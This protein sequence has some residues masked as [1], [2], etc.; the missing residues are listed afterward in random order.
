MKERPAQYGC[1]ATGT[2]Q[3][4]PGTRRAVWAR[5][6]CVRWPRR[7]PAGKC[8]VAARHPCRNS[9]RR[10]GAAT[11]DYALTMGVVLP[12]A[13]IVLWFGPRILRLVYEFTSSVIGWPFQ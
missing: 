8:C 10:R 9:P 7:S 1:Q 12:M 3:V 6:C 5:P 11:L 4:A 13:G 2:R